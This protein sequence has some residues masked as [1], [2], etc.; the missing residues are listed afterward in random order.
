MNGFEVSQENL[1]CKM[2]HNWFFTYSKQAQSSKPANKKHRYHE[3]N[4]GYS[5]LKI[6]LQNKS[7]SHPQLKY[8]KINYIKVL[9]WLAPI[10]QL[11]C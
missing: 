5:V 7:K 1:D 10:S 2:N 4:K 9:H 11:F 3:S 6:W 8:I